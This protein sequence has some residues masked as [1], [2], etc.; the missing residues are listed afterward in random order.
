MPTH[1]LKLSCQLWDS[2]KYHIS[3][4]LILRRFVLGVGRPLW[5]AWRK[6]CKVSIILFRFIF[7]NRKLCISTELVHDFIRLIVCQVS[8]TKMYL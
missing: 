1:H 3:M 2:N 7:W 8:E 4:L 6:Q 5:I